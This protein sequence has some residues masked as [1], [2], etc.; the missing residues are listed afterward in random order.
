M[1]EV[2]AAQVKQ[3]RELTG[4]GMMDCKR[5][6]VECDGDMEKAKDWLRA[7]GMARAADKAGRDQRGRRR[8]VC[9]RRRSLRAEARRARRAELRVGLR[10]QDG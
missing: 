8:G 9:P 3:L 1:A 2:T 6:L 4:A 5:A 10:R 7:K